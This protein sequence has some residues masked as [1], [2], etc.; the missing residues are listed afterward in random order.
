MTQVKKN[1][2]LLC[3]R[4]AG[5]ST[6]VAAK[7]T[8]TLLKD[9]RAEVLLLAP[10]ERQSAELMIKVK[11]FY[12]ASG[13]AIP[14]VAEGATHLQLAN[15]SR[16]IALPSTEKTV[17]CYGG[18]S[19][20]IIDEASR[21]SDEFYRAVRPMVAVSNGQLWGLTT[22]FGKRGWFYEE[23]KSGN[24]DAWSRIKVTADNVPRLSAAFLQDERESMGQRWYAQEYECSFEENV[25]SVFSSSA[26]EQAF[27]DDVAPLFSWAN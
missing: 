26:I 10:S 13:A 27:T 19:M 20:L 24:A 4:Q 12:H 25:G 23:W 7:V 8:H 18:L 9:A 21:V 17:R 16:A 3:S 11:R 1:L 22:P 6:V 5:K 15:G 2:L 14:I